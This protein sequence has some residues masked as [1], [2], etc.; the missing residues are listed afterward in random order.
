MLQELGIWLLWTLAV[1]PSNRATIVGSKALT[2]VSI[3]DSRVERR[4]ARGAF[5]GSYLCISFF[6][7]ILINSLKQNA[8]QGALLMARTYAYHSG[9]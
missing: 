8:A 2:V 7:V 5:D 3:L 1:N 4:I 9:W 6:M